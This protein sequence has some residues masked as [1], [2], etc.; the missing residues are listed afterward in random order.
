MSWISKSILFLC[1]LAIFTA[2]QN[3][4]E[5]TKKP[6]LSQYH[7]ITG[8][9]LSV[10]DKVLWDRKYSMEQGYVYGKEPAEILRLHIEI[11][12]KGKTLDIA[13]G[14]GRNAVYLARNGFDVDGVDISE[15][16]IKKARSLA[17]EFG[18][19]INPILADLTT[20][21]IKENYYDLIVNINYLQRSLVPEIIKGLRPGG[22]VVFETYTA[23]HAK[24]PGQDDFPEEWLLKKGELKELFKGFEVI[25]YRET[26]NEKEALASLIARKPSGK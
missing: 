26:K 9:D 18:V 14:E 3:T 17:R 15:V 12:P 6:S 7:L 4:E 19:Q 11:F 1:F 21:Q 20:Y 23:D 25:L 16:A 2:C 24:L 5:S 13:M 22:Y 8:H 10:D